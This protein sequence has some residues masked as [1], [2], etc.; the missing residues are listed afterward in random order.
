MKNLIFALIMTL[1]STAIGATGV[2]DINNLELK[3]CEFNKVYGVLSSQSKQFQADVRKNSIRNS[4]GQL[5]Q[6]ESNLVLIDSRRMRDLNL[7]SRMIVLERLANMNNAPPPDTNPQDGLLYS[8]L[9]ELR[10]Q[11]PEGQITIPIYKACSVDYAIGRIEILGLEEASN[12]KAQADHSAKILE[13][14][15]A[16]YG[17]PLPMDKLSQ[18]EQ[19]DIA[20][21]TGIL[22]IH[23]SSIE[24]GMKMEA[25]RIFEHASEF[26]NDVSLHEQS[27]IGADLSQF[28]TTILNRVNQKKL[29]APLK[30]AV[31][32]LL[33]MDKDFPSD[34]TIQMSKNSQSIKQPD[35]ENM[36][37]VK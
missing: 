5:S 4:D 10:N 22:K 32:L 28:S 18:S 33:K 27:A 37:R 30:A 19:T 25:I 21:A 35:S 8:Y 2:S 36:G 15:K 20:R 16:R 7:I 24:F 23:S 34:Q 9:T 3:D 17:D 26:I 29:N 13:Q 12:T 31:I 11:I 14:Y 1:T 6:E